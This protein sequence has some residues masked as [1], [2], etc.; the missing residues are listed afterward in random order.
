MLHEGYWTLNQLKKKMEEHKI[1]IET[2]P[3]GKIKVDGIN[4]GL[5]NPT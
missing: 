2:Y 5:R 3:N 4:I 1:Q